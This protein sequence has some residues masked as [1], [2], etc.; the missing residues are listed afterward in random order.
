MENKKDTLFN[1]IAQEA[2]IIP[3]L[4]TL[5]LKDKKA[6]FPEVR[7]I[8]AIR[9]EKVPGVLTVDVST[10]DENGEPMVVYHG[11]SSTDILV[12]DKSKGYKPLK[13]FL[14]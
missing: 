9:G 2:D 1:L 14:S 3:F 4:K 12:F 7:K 10:L 13:T 8:H 5:D 11:S 6:L